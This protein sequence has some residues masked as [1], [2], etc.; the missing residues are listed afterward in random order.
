MVDMATT[1]FYVILQLLSWSG[2]HPNIV[3]DNICGLHQLSEAIAIESQSD[4][5]MLDLLA[6]GFEESKYA[7]RGNLVIS[8]RGACGVFQQIPKYAEPS[9]LPRPSCSDLRDPYVSSFRAASALRVLRERFGEDRFC[10]YNA[11]NVCWSRS[12]SY[13]GRI[14]GLR[15]RIRQLLGSENLPSKSTLLARFIRTRNLCEML[16]AEIH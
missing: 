12:F 3:E 14:Y 1:A 9:D 6:V 7:Y 2:A 8:R 13:Q 15:R 16:N 4:D 11:G 5:E 10:H